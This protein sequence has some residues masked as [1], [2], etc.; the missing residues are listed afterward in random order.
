MSI[1]PNRL[2]MRGGEEK[3][4]QTRYWVNIGGYGITPE[5]LELTGF[6]GKMPIGEGINKK[7]SIE[8]IFGGS[9]RFKPLPG[10]RF[11]DRLDKVIDGLNMILQVQR[12]VQDMIEWI[13]KLLT[14]QWRSDD[15]V[16]L[17][18][19]TPSEV[20][21]M[22]ESIQRRKYTITSDP[23][24]TEQILQIRQELQSLK[25][26]I[27]Y[28]PSLYREANTLFQRMVLESVSMSM[29]NLS[30]RQEPQYVN[31]EDL[32]DQAAESIMESS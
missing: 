32:A 23:I 13:P 26:R 18:E 8:Q 15:S 29:A 22:I 16:T 4:I 21:T 28:F 24:T 3:L 14:E 7:Q 11:E 10:K 6:W 17:P 25:E 20:R 9:L 1:T 27:G 30:M 31:L 5:M 19:D 2:Q 12:H